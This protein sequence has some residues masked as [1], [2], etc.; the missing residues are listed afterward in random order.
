[1]KE[2]Q[3]QYSSR[4]YL[5]A[6]YSIDPGQPMLYQHRKYLEKSYVNITILF[7]DNLPR[8]QNVSLMIMNY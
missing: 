1:M 6:K 2:V 4:L 8:D 7:K 5:G 3:P